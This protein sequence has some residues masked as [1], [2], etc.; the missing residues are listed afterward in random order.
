MTTRAHLSSCL[1]NGLTF[2]GRTARAK[3]W[4]CA[5]AWGVGAGALRLYDQIPA[6]G[7][8]GPQ[9]LYNLVGLILRFILALA[10]VPLL[11][12]GSRRLQDTGRAGRWV[13]V[14]VG[15]Y[16]AGFMLV[17]WVYMFSGVDP[18]SPKEAKRL[19][20]VFSMA[21]MA[22]FALSLLT[23]L[24]WMTQPSQPGTNAYGPPPAGG[25]A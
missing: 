13:F 18:W 1:R 17:M 12:A 22:P 4:R 10:V 7:A 2:S 25:A 19:F 6:Q 20:G 9:A 16:L 3:F 14:P 23:V 21:A 5:L 24:V 8:L 15:L 11:A